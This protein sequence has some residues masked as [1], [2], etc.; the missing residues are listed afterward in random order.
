MRKL[1]WL[2]GFALLATLLWYFF[3]KQEHYQ[4]RFTTSQPPGMV[5]QHLNDW[6][7]LDTKDSL[8]VLWKKGT[9]YSYVQQ[10]VIKDQD[11]LDYQWEIQRINDSITEVKARVTDTKQFWRRKFEAPL[12]LGHFVSDNVARVKNVGTN[13]IEKEEKFEIE[14]ISD[15]LFPSKF[16]AYVSVSNVPVKQKTRK[17]LSE[18]SLVMGYIK[19]HDIPLDGDPF[20]Q[21][22]RW[23]QENNSIDFDFCF[24]IQKKDSLPPSSEVKFKTTES[25]RFL[26]AIFHGNYKISDFAWYYLLDHAERNQLDIALLPTELYLNDPHAGG[27]S[28]DWEAHIFV[29]L[30]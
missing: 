11:T 12:H 2:I 23:D 9:R 27:N 17:M 19:S 7:L 8:K 28:L 21:V 20:L 25:Q 3:L 15:T 30:K 13:L 6:S 4:I 22:T 1:K 10:T 18:I 26:K 24:P 5:Y 29:P 14:A 16:C